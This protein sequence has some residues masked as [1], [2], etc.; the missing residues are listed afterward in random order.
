MLNKPIH[1]GFT[2]LDLEKSLTYGFHYNFFKK[3]FDAGSLFTDT[4]FLQNVY[5]EFFQWKDL[6]YLRNYLKDF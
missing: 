4:E 1:V 2:V 5:K 6:F 3:L